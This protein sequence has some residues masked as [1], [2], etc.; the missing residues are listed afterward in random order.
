[1]QCDINPAIRFSSDS[2]SSTGSH[3]ESN[4][5]KMEHGPAIEGHGQNLIGAPPQMLARNSRGGSGF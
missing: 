3:L 1:M 5:W 2:T 4:G